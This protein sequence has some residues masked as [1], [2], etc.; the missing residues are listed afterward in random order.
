MFP[1]K[2]LRSAI[3]KPIVSTILLPHKLLKQLD[4]KL[5]TWY[6]NLTPDGEYSFYI[7][8]KTKYL[9]REKQ[10]KHEYTSKRILQKNSTIA[11]AAAY[12][13]TWM[14]EFK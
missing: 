10:V 1:V 13:E 2:N 12:K 11:K 7:N 9:Q 3:G 4:E 5:N 6:Q 8:K 14:P